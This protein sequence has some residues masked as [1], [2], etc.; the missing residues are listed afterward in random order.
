MADNHSNAAAAEQH[1]KRIIGPTI[2]M[3]DGAYFDYEADHAHGMTIED[4]A[5]GLASTNRFRGQTRL[6]T[7]NGI[8]RRC[9]YNVAQHVVWLTWHMMDDGCSDEQA[10]EGLMHESDEVPWG[11]FPGPA[12]GLL[13]E[14]AATVVKANGDAIDRHFGVTHN[15]KALVKQYD[16]RMLATEKRDLMPHSGVDRWE[17]TKGYEPFPSQIEPWSAEASADEF[18]ALY[19][20]LTRRL[21]RAAHD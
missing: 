16:I 2:L 3:G 9:L 18:Q 13:G 1:V 17:W 4:Y 14:Q 8:G 5:W 6:R 20:E 15:H 11:D 10:F 19:R 12:K 21:G 7:Y